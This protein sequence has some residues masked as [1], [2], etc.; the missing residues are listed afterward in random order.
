[1]RQYLRQAAGGLPVGQLSPRLFPSQEFGTSA[2][3]AATAP[4]SRFASWAL[5]TR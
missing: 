2:E 1:V 3:R 5:F 4:T